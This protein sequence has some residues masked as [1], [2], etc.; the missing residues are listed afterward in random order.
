MTRCDDEARGGLDCHECGHSLKCPLCCSNTTD[1][2]RDRISE[3]VDEVVGWRWLGSTVEL[4]R[5][6][7]GFDWE[8]VGRNTAAVAASLK[9]NSFA[10]VVEL[11]ETSVEFSWKHW[12]KD[13]PFV[14]RDRVLEELVDVGHFLA[15][16][17][18][19]IGVTDAEWAVAYQDKQEKN[20]RRMSSGAYSAKKGRLG[21]GSDVE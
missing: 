9:D 13:D 3:H 15:N 2:E 19:A 12:A 16:M 4:Q 5:D 17:L 1:E 11:A 20:R 7:F 6:Y 8:K 14:N 21:E 10:I 18:V